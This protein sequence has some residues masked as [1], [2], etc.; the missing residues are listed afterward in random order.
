MFTTILLADMV[1][2]GLI[3]LNDPVDKYLPSNVKAPQYDGHKITIEDL[4]THTSGLPEYPP[5]Y[6]AGD[7]TVY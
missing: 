4:A 7:W 6:T 5:N 2:E 1:Q 3:K